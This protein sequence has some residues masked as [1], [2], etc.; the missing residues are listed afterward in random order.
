MPINAQRC[1]RRSPPKR[2]IDLIGMV[3]NVAAMVIMAPAFT[4]DGDFDVAR[5][6]V[7]VIAFRG[8]PTDTLPV[9]TANGPYPT[10]AFDSSIGFVA[11]LLSDGELG[12]SHAW[13]NNLPARIYAQSPR[14]WGFGFRLAHGAVFHTQP[15]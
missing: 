3:A 4:V 2:T 15:W 11:S 1:A 12:T 8:I 7:H 5:A 14:K 10:R 9:K 13:L 6:C